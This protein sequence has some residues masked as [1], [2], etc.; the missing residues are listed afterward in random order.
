MQEKN[1]EVTKL[2]EKI[3]RIN[4]LI[5]ASTSGEQENIHKEIADTKALVA[6][7]NVRKENFESRL[8]DSRRKK[9]NIKEKISNLEKE[10]SEIKTSSPEIKKQQGK[11]EE[12]QKEFDILE[13]KR[14][15][16]YLIK[17]ELST[18]EN[19][20]SEKQKFLIET[21]KE[22]ELIEGNISSL[23]DEIK[24]VKSIEKASSLKQET[25]QEMR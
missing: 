8:E 11:Q 16:F 14:R 4:K 10:I 13:R 7:F 17:S 21:K 3:I 9:H 5:Q 25:I 24:Y 23:A 22:L 20:K 2:E 12:Y 1:N 19:K 18:Q 6:G 15:K